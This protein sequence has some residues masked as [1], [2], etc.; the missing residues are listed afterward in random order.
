MN[1]YCPP[2]R[3]LRTHSSQ[4]LELHT[5][6]WQFLITKYPKLSLCVWSPFSNAT[7]SQRNQIF[8][9]ESEEN[10]NGSVICQI[11]GSVHQSLSYFTIILKTILKVERNFLNQ[12]FPKERKIK[13]FKRKKSWNKKEELNI[14]NGNIF[15]RTVTSIWNTFCSI[16]FMKSNGMR[17]L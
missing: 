9:R 17:S 6:D 15:N 12:I 1:W 16:I 5:F 8:F 11:I 3:I 10:V 2:L 14:S 7:H 13:Y 4:H